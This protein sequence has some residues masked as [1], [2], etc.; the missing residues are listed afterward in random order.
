MSLPSIERS[1]ILRPAAA[2]AALSKASAVI[3]VAPVNPSVHASPPLVAAPGVVNLV[4]PALQ[5]QSSDDA[6][7]QSSVPDPLKNSVAAKQAPHDW[8]LKRAAAE[9][10]EDPPKKPISEVL[11]DNLKSIWTASASAIQIEQVGNQLNRPVPT[12]P[13]QIPGDLAKQVLTYQPTRIKKNEK[14]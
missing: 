4:N 5:A 13:S 12:Q 6:T 3:P 9:K 2:E 14:V 7:A 8:T 10:V 1:S 11:L